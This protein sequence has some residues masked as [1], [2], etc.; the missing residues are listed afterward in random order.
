MKKHPLHRF[1]IG[2]PHR[3]HITVSHGKIP[4][5]QPEDMFYINNKSPFNK[6]KVF[7][8]QFLTNYPKRFSHMHLPVL[9]YEDG[10]LFF[11]VQIDNLI[12]L[13]TFESGGPSRRAEMFVTSPVCGR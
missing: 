1:Q 10:I 11:S 6:H 9:Q 8:I 4:I 13:H 12:I 5:R 7:R 2:S 3:Q